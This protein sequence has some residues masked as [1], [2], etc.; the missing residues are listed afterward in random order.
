MARTNEESK[1][2]PGGKLRTATTLCDQ[3]E[4]EWRKKKGGP[5]RK[6]ETIE[7]D[8]HAKRKATLTWG[9]KNEGG[10]KESRARRAARKRLSKLMVG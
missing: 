5:E 1:T 6:D 4:K 9:N 10:S 8:D 2:R 7:G 3:K